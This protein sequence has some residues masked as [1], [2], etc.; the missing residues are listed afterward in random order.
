M[1]KTC[2]HIL[3][4]IMVSVLTANKFIIA[5]KNIVMQLQTYDYRIF[6]F[7]YVSVKICGKST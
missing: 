1:L 4:E 2:L 5:K 7:A 3:I 6:L